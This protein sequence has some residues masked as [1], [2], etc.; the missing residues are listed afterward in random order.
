MNSGIYA[1]HEVSHGHD[2]E[3]SWLLYEA[4]GALGDRKLTIEIE[5][6]SIKTV[7]VT[8]AEGL[9][10]GGAVKNEKHDTDRHWCHRLKALIGLV[11]SWQLTG[12]TSYLAAAF[13]VW[14]FIE[15]WIID[16]QNGEWFWRLMKLVRLILLKTK[17]G[18]GSVHNHN[19]RA[20]IELLN[21]LPKSG[22][23]R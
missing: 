5:R 23:V 14:D 8:Q 12:Q 16:H 4:S 11:N 2:I 10:E 20:I 6:I 18:R 17:L 1:S 21:R 13:R 3:G 19:G 7:D 22:E 15:T 9:E